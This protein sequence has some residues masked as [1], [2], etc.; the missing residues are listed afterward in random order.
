[1]SEAGTGQRVRLTAIITTFNEERNIVACLRSASWADEIL[2]V[3]SYSTDATVSLAR[4]LAHRLLQHPYETPA[5]QKN[6][7]ME[8]ARHRWVLILDADER[9]TGTLKDEIRELLRSRPACAG[10]WIFRRNRFLDRE[11]RWGGWGTDRVIRLVDR[12]SARYPD[13]RVHEEMDV[14]GRVGVLSG[15]LEHRTFDSFV[16]YAEKME[17]YSTWWA[18]DRLD[19]GRRASPWTV[20]T[21]T[22]GRFVRMYL[23]KG[24]VLDGGYG[25][26]LAL[27]ASYSVFLKYAK[28]WEG[29][30]KTGGE[31]RPDPPPGGPETPV[32]TGV[33]VWG[34]DDGVRA[35]LLKRA[36]QGR[37]LPLP[38][39]SMARG[40]GQ[41]GPTGRGQVVIGRLGGHDAVL[42]M[43]RHGGWF[44]KA[45]GLLPGD[46]ASLY[47]TLR[48]LHRGARMVRALRRRG[49]HTPATV[50]WM[51]VRR[52]VFW[53]LYS[54]TVLVP[55]ART[56]DRP[57]IAGEIRR[58][59]LMAAAGR[60]LARW[61]H[62]GLVH[63]D[64]N[65]GNIL[66]A[67]PGAGAPRPE[68]LIVL[69][70]DG[71]RVVSSVRR[72]VRVASL[73][74]LERSA[75]KRLGPGGLKAANRLRFLAAYGREAAVL[76]GRPAADSLHLVR[77]F[78][79]ALMRRRLFFPLHGVR[80]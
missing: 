9:V 57:M 71:A 4:P 16:S 43:H 66:L 28:L 2:V 48:R 78:L 29:S 79:P 37:G 8:Q 30:R 15:R 23:L 75:L 63:P 26:I 55:D 14:K 76:E 59:R 77:A 61:H 80:P 19:A 74:R 5:R 73:A 20:F 7:A 32:R 40:P 24:G 38:A 60:A 27:L 18:L 50:G 11:M 72:R 39:S 45:L 22:L 58:D 13:V 12:R 52:G 51:A 65:L 21:H 47:L 62:A 34:A 70:L 1:M 6:W 42:K 46:G 33:R 54:A 41:P 64:L 35:D 49:C 31:A 10:Y 67:C 25:L 53:R 44:G 68:D 36:L 3:D 17:R 56:L 69:D